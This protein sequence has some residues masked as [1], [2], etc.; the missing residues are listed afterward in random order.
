MHVRA[1]GHP[2]K[3]LYRSAPICFSSKT[4]HVPRCSGLR[5][6]TVDWIEPPTALTTRFRSSVAT[7]PA[8]KMFRSAKY[9][10]ARSPIGKRDRT[11]VAPDSAISSSLR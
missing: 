1:F 6:D 9:C 10:V 7:R 5:S 8:Q 2:S 11:T 3:R 4:S